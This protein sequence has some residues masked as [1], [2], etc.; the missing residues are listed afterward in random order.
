MLKRVDKGLAIFCW[1]AAAV[2]VVMLLAGPT[3]VA[4]DSDKAATK[5]AAGASPYAATTATT[6]PDGKALFKSNCGSCHTLS[7]AGTTGTVGPKLD[8]IGLNAAAVE[9]VM[10]AGPGVMPSFTSS[11]SPAERAAV[12]KFVAGG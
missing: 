4:H 2:L 9:A 6:A 3:V 12:A 11:L 1:I 5:A 8:G 10:K 7:A